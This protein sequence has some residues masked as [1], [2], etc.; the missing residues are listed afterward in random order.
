MIRHRHVHF[1]VHVCCLQHVQ[2]SM[3]RIITHVIVADLA[4]SVLLSVPLEGKALTPSLVNTTGSWFC[5]LVV[6]CFQRFG[7]GRSWF[8]Y[9]SIAHLKGRLAA[10]PTARRPGTAYGVSY[11][12]ARRV[13]CC[14]LPLEDTVVSSWHWWGLRHIDRACAL[15]D[16]VGR[17]L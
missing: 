10:G 2:R 8:G 3:P 16:C 6:S 11:C 15:L 13:S 12:H 17:L 14:R 5:Q 9:V 1:W 7:V 4:W